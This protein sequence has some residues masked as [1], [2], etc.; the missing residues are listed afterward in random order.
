MISKVWVVLY[1]TMMIVQQ[2]AYS[3]YIFLFLLPLALFVVDWK[4]KM[5]VILLLV[6]NV[7]C[8]VHPSLWWRL[9]MPCYMKPADIFSS[10]QLFT[11]YSMQVAIVLLTGYFIW[12]AFPR[13]KSV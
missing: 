13:Q 12:L 2:S 4:S 11:D 10:S 9:G 6:F 1:A 8:V 7:L 5:Q 3:N